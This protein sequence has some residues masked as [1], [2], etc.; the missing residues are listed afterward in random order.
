MTK[1]NVNPD[2]YKTAGRER[3]GEDIVQE[4][5]KQKFTQA[6]A[7][8]GGQP[9]TPNFIPGAAPVGESRTEANDKATHGAAETVGQV[10]ESANSSSNT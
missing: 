2:H 6:E 4:I 5:H 3:Q 7:A 9:G 1:S 8:R 10:N